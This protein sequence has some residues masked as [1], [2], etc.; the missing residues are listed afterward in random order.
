[1]LF[2]G[3][4]LDWLSEKIRR[5]DDHAVQTLALA[6]VFNVG[7]TR[8]ILSE[9]TSLYISPASGSIESIIL[10]AGSTWSLPSEQ[11]WAVEALVDATEY[12]MWCGEEELQSGISERE[13]MRSTNECADLLTA[14]VK[15][16]VTN[17]PTTREEFLTLMRFWTEPTIK[18]GPEGKALHVLHHWG[19][20][21]HDRFVN[22]HLTAR[23]LYPL[24]RTAR[25]LWTAL[26]EPAVEDWI[27]F[28]NFWQE[29]EIWR[30]H[31]EFRSAALGADVSSAIRE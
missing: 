5:E 6:I 29:M 1:L 17:D 11:D 21:Y 24:W 27:K 16:T 14:A 31:V 3:E 22:D 30:F 23:S 10:S 18:L 26:D 9:L 25:A 8:S 15:I 7:A 28:Q 12:L 2:R 4:F 19:P 13:D 20:G